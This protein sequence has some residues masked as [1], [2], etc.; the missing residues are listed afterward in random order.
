MQIQAIKYNIPHF[1]LREEAV[2]GR[3]GGLACHTL[4]L[5]SG[6]VDPG[7]WGSP[8]NYLADGGMIYAN[9]QGKR[10]RRTLGRDGTLRSERGL[11]MWDLFLLNQHAG[12]EM[13]LLHS[14]MEQMW[15]SE[16][17][18]S[19]FLLPPQIATV[20]KSVRIADMVFEWA[21]LGHTGVIYIHLCFWIAFLASIR[22]H[23][24]YISSSFI[25]LTHTHTKD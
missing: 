24:C 18:F 16:I 25:F 4:C 13:Q 21:T 22:W 23:L 3:F 8:R 10:E 17:S 14:K 12:T 15:T 11:T 6:L 7:F 9:R 5:R 1:S 20:S 2:Q 19:F